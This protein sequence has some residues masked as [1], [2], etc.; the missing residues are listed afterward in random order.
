MNRMDKLNLRLLLAF[1][2]AALF[3]FQTVGFAQRAALA[4]MP[5][6]GD[7]V[8]TKQQC[9]NY[10]LKVNPK[11]AIAVSP[12]SL[13]EHYYEEGKREGVRPDVAFAQAMHET[14]FFRYGGLVSPSQ[15]NYCGLGS[16]GAGANGAWFSNPRLGVRAHI[17]H[18]LAYSSTRLPTGEIVDPRY[19]LVKTTGNFGAART[20]LDLNGKWAVPGNDYAQR[21]MSIYS[22]ILAER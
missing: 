5:I 15:N 16:V 22:A 17:Q 4:A 20:W 13:V 19:A 9:L 2:C 1:F 14:G 3:S 8:A 10:L 11:P 7:P 18:I 21:I 12:Q 6:M